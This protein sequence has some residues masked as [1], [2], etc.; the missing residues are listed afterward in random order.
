MTK[1]QNK[2]DKARDKIDDAVIY[3]IEALGLDPRSFTISSY[4]DNVTKDSKS[5]T[6]TVECKYDDED[7][8]GNPL[9]SEV[10]AL[11][12]KLDS[13]DNRIK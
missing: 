5:F 1:R 3:Y 2:I 4:N 12:K 8:Q 10:K 13:L 6:Y 7:D 9:T 11:F